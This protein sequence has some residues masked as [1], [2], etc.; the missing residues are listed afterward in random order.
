[1]KLNPRPGETW[2]RI[3][4]P[5]GGQPGYSQA[6]TVEHVTETTVELLVRCDVMRRMTFALDT[7]LDLAGLG[8]FLVKPD[9]VAP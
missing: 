3:T 5:N 1:M 9:V 4:P 2:L 8:S 6:G 7:G